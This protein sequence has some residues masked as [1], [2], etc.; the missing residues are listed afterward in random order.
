MASKLGFSTGKGFFPN[1]N[2]EQVDS[3]HTAS[4]DSNELNIA[5]NYLRLVSFI[6]PDTEFKSFTSS[7]LFYPISGNFSTRDFFIIHGTLK[8]TVSYDVY[9]VLR[10]SG[11]SARQLIYLP[12]GTYGLVDLSM[13]INGGMLF[14]NAYKITVGSSTTPLATEC[15]FKLNGCYKIVN[16]DK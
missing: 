11:N 9:F 1:V 14:V 5:A 8:Y 15:S 6:E 2:S 10:Y 13:K 16:S 4:N 3:S 12:E 7:G